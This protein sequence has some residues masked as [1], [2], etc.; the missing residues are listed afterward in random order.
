MGYKIKPSI[1]SKEDFKEY[2][3][4]IKIECG[5]PMT[6]A[7]HYDAILKCFESLKVNPFIN[8]VRDAPSLRQFGMDV[9]RQILKKWLSSIR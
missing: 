6:A 3:N 7:K 9:R 8:P 1:K 2:I 4:Y 5:M